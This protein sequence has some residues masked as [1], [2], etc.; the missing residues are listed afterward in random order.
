VK[1]PE[2]PSTK[3]EKAAPGRSREHQVD[4]AEWNWR[5]SLVVLEVMLG[6]PIHTF[7]PQVLDQIEKQFGLG[8]DQLEIPLKYVAVTYLHYKNQYDIPTPKFLNRQ[9][10]KVKKAS[11]SLRHI[12]AD[13][14]PFF[15]RLLDEELSSRTG[16]RLKTTAHGRRRTSLDEIL[17]VLISYSESFKPLLRSGAPRKDYLVVTARSLIDFWEEQF[18]EFKGGYDT[19]LHKAGDEFTAEGPRFIQ[20]VLQDLDKTLNLKQ[21]ERAIRAAR[22]AKKQEELAAPSNVEIPYTEDDL[23]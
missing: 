6:K 10:G 18:G 11:E 16:V 21:V 22:A 1:N 9:A 17:T 2:K 19:A 23:F 13:L 5:P 7:S 3:R 8:R 20:F 4:A 14:P 15:E 12:L